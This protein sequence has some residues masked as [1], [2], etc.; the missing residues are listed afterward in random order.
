MTNPIQYPPDIYNILYT[1]EAG[2]VVGLDAVQ[3][4]DPIP[5]N[6]VPEL[7][8]QLS[9]DDLYL[10]YQCGLVLAAWGVEEGVSYLQSLV[11]SRIDKIAEFEP[12]RLWGEDNVYD[13][14]S[15]A[16]GVAVLSD[17][18]KSEIVNILR[19]VLQLYG[20]CYFE[21][22]LKE[23]LI[24]LDEESLLPDIKR[25]MQLAL[26]NQRYYQA[27]QLLPVLAKHDNA[28]ALAQVSMFQ[29]LVQKDGRVRFNLEVMQAYL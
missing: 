20:E 13:V 19:D 4:L 26:D 14:I 8:A 24:R 17:Y 12:H 16:L 7:I 9:G 6:R 22:K 2:E 1:D 21:S 27:S 23:V 15:E 5:V 29:D 25:A 10:A 28:Y 3:L 11:A 18:D